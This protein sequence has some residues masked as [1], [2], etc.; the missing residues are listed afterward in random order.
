MRA[1][2]AKMIMT[3]KPAFPA[4]VM[5]RSDVAIVMPPR[6]VTML[7]PTTLTCVGNS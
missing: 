7:Y 5:M 4:R 2:A 3:E 1:K 6:T